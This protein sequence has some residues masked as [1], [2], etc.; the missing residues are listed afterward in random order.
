[1]GKKAL[2]F[3]LLLLPASLLSSCGFLIWEA[4]T[5]TDVSFPETSPE[6]PSSSITDPDSFRV[7]YT[8]HYGEP[9]YVLYP[10]I[11]GYYEGEL[12]VPETY[13]GEEGILPVFEIGQSAFAGTGVTS[14]VFSENLRCIET[15]AFY[16]CDRLEELTLHD[17]SIGYAAFAEC[18]SLRSVFYEGG[19]LDT[20]DFQ[21]GGDLVIYTSL[22]YGGSI[23]LGGAKVAAGVIDH[24]EQG[25]F[26]YG[27][28]EFPD[29]GH[30][31]LIA[32]YDGTEGD[33]IVPE[34]IVHEE[35]SLE[36]Y[37][38][39]P[40]AFAGKR[41][42]SL[43]LPET[44]R[45]IVSSAFMECEL[46][47]R[48]EIPPKVFAVGRASFIRTSGLEEI[49]LPASLAVLGSYA[50]E[51]SVD[52]RK[53]TLA[54]DEDI[55]VPEWEET[56][57]VYGHALYVDSD[58]H[59]PGGAFSG[60]LSLEEIEWPNNLSYI[61]GGCFEGCSSLHTISLPDFEDGLIVDPKAFEGCLSLTSISLPPGVDLSE[62]SFAGCPNL[63]DV[64]FRGPVAEKT[65]G[66]TDFPIS[67]FRGTGVAELEVEGY[68]DFDAFLPSLKYVHA[69]LD[70][71][72]GYHG[73]PLDQD[74]RSAYLSNGTLLVTDAHPELVDEPNVYTV[75][76]IEE[77]WERSLMVD[78]S[79]YLIGIDVEGNA[80]AW[81]VHPPEEA[82]FLEIPD[83]VHHEIEGESQAFPVVGVA[84]NAF[85]G[86]PS[87][88]GAIFPS[89][90]RYLPAVTGPENGEASPTMYFRDT[91]PFD[92]VLPSHPDIERHL[93]EGFDVHSG[94]GLGLRLA[95]YLIEDGIVFGIYEDES[96]GSKSAGA[97]GLAGEVPETL[98]IPAR[99]GASIPVRGFPQYAFSHDLTGL[100]GIVYE[101]QS[102]QGD[103]DPYVLGGDSLFS[104]P[105]LES[106]EYEGP[107]TPLYLETSGLFASS[108]R[109]LRFYVP[110]G[111]RISV[112]SGDAPFA[113]LERLSIYLGDSLEEQ[114]F[115]MDDDRILF[116]DSGVD[117]HFDCPRA[118]YLSL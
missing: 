104:A 61:R 34:T 108:T 52:L 54:G 69:K 15:N 26:R 41:L 51:D 35:K 53:V 65:V 63:V 113:G 29:G 86:C 97:L 116:L 70:D 58:E 14:I 1:M 60:C 19:C 90:L 79:R 72:R 76:L 103:V 105:D 27:V 106:F 94:T 107:D 85:A 118:E 6:I 77:V 59:L 32:S 48:I 30:G 47:S 117:L 68:P 46:P 44:L 109:L 23:D 101:T 10:L 95:D 114:R 110:R 66:G 18:D 12:V 93:G 62:D 28:R 45:F 115:E 49:V 92:S 17:I 36:V 82:A 31:A 73:S 9:G 88:R 67:A 98:V 39:G 81:L 13:E 112:S 50:F 75:F 22:G 2:G 40:L 42:T 16:D 33:V 3:L 71:E 20:N 7:E 96:T 80:V 38:I 21:D 43:E 83:Y 102:P 24:G 56:D 99:V 84:A 74:V 25:G 78:S 37:G 87:L 5:S 4:E 100:R 57:R 64:T 91:E 8:D 111:S 89:T 11:M 55:P